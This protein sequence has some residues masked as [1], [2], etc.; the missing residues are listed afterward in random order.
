MFNSP[1]FIKKSPHGR[2]ICYDKEIGRG[3]FKTVN[4]AYDTETGIEL[5]WNSVSIEN[6]DNKSKQQI[7]EELNILRSISGKCEYI[8]KYYDSWFD[9]ISKEVIFVTELATAGSIVSYL[10]KVKSVTLNVSKKWA[11]QILLGINFL[12]ENNIIHRDINCGNIFVNSNTGNILIGDFGTCKVTLDS[13]TTLL[14]TPLYMAPEIWIGGGYSLPADIYSFGL[15]ILQII[16]NKI[17][18]QEF[19]DRPLFVSASFPDPPK[20][21]DEV[22]DESGKQFILK[23]ISREPEN[24][25]SIEELLNDPFLIISIAP[26]EYSL[27]NLRQVVR[28][29]STPNLPP[30]ISTD[31]ENSKNRRESS[32]YNPKKDSPGRARELARHSKRDSPRD[33]SR[34]ITPRDSPRDSSL[35]T[36]P[37]DSPLGSPIIRSPKNSPRD[38]LK[39]GDNLRISEGSA[40]IR[41]ARD[42]R[43]P[44]ESPSH[45]P[46]PSPIRRKSEGLKRKKPIDNA[47]RSDGH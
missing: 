27:K 41:I 21:L 42:R 24:R 45:S 13:C 15:C 6:L 40:I 25:P 39:S 47:I 36:T 3:S 9:K 38:S 44:R 43:S 10:K 16:T 14:G 8:M 7:L 20:I 26:E 29:K 28:H 19:R 35:S 31:S 11:K 5:A 34:F 37:K 33:S 17:P 30:I 2:Y 46:L 12:H 22:T 1:V 23:C 32:K 4:L 18:Y